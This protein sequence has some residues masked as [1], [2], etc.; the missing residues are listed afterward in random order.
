MKK[1]VIVIPTYNE[2]ENIKRLTET[3]FDVVKPLKD[4]QFEIVIVDSNSPDRTADIVKSLQ[5][6]NKA[7]HLVETAKEGLG[8]AYIRGFDYALDTLLPDVLFEMDADYSHDPKVIPHFIKKIEAGADFVIGSRYRKGGSIPKD[9]G[10]DRKIFSVIGN[11]II[12]LGFMK[13]KVTDWTSGY[14]AIKADIVRESEQH[15]EKFTGYVFQVAILDYAIKNHAVV[16]EVPIRFT[17][18]KYGVSKI[19]SGQY[20][21][22]TLWYVF[23]HSS[24]IKFVITGGI[25]FFLDFAILYLL[26]RVVGWPIWLSQLLSAESAVLSNF[27]FNNFWSFSYKRQAGKRRFL[28]NLIKFHGV[29]TGSLLMQTTAITAYEFFFGDNYVFV[30]KVFMIFVVII[31]YSYILYNRVVWKQKKKK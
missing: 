21:S 1:A 14:R 2:A 26:Y 8:K 13:L 20:I 31:P 7:V 25:G 6:T 16:A 29:S 23:T 11:L 15:V 19:N 10:I 12:R 24:F 5:K 3:I 27:M 22:N 17:D 4:W 30:F 18:R 28:K 9:W